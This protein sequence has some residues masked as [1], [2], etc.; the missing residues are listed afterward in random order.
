M[1]K[2]ILIGRITKDLEL[3]ASASGMSYLSF[4]L[5][6]NRRGKDK[7]AD[8]ITCKAFSKT[9]EFINTYM[10]KGRQIAVEGRIQ[11]G[12]YDKDGAKVYTTDVICDNVYFADSA[13]KAVGITINEEA[14][15]TQAELLANIELPF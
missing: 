15:P 6:V 7:E 12:S 1:N 14:E 9:A 3:K 4:T 11:T 10:S 13:Q 2:A 5:A 8:F